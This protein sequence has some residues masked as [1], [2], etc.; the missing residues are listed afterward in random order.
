MGI[1]NETNKRYP[2][3][4]VVWAVEVNYTVPINFDA[5]TNRQGSTLKKRLH[6]KNINTRE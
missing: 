1:E 3:V 2:C 4:Q 6:P 5:K